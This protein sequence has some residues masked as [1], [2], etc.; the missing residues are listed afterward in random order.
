MNTTKIT[1]VGA[2]IFSTKLWNHMLL[3]SDGLFMM[4][5]ANTN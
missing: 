5:S 1:E 3:D 2:D 4:S